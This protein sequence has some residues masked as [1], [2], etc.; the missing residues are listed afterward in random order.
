MSSHSP[1]RRVHFTPPPMPDTTAHPSPRSARTSSATLSVM[2]PPPPPKVLE[3]SFRKRDNSYILPGES[4]FANGPGASAVAS[5]FASLRPNSELPPKSP[6][7]LYNDMCAFQLDA[8]M[9]SHHFLRSLDAF[10][11]KQQQQL[12][13]ASRQLKSQEEELN[14]Q[15]K[16]KADLSHLLEDKDRQTA[17][18]KAVLDLVTRSKEKE[19][20]RGA[21]Q[22]KRV[23]AKNFRLGWNQ[24]LTREED[25]C[26]GGLDEFDHYY[27]FALMCYSPIR[28]ILPG[29]VPSPTSSTSEGHG[30]GDEE[31]S[32]TPRSK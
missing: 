13:E 1:L 32:S 18:L 3:L 26:Y 15:M 2:M 31:V 4:M 23:S 28:G 9:A 11:L 21:A 24:A 8:L 29:D 30:H 6:K 27:G 25:M 12:D 17:T 7:E 16:T 19:F 14:E 10:Q 20:E 22:M 5:G